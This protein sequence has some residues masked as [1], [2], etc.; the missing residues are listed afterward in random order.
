MATGKLL[1]IGTPIGNLGDMSRRAVEAIRSCSRL[2]CE[3]TRH[4]RKLLSHFRISAKVESFHEHNEDQKA[5]EVIEAIAGGETIGL[6]S[7]A[8]MPVLSDPGFALVQAARERGITVEPIP[9]PVAAILALVASGIAP[10]PFTFYGFAPHRS[11]ERREFYRSIAAST[12]TAIVY[13]SPERVVDSLR[14]ALQELGDVAAT[15]AREMTKVHEEFLHGT[16]SQII[17]TLEARK[18]IKGEL[19]IVLAA[20]SPLQAH[21]DPEA[22][23]TEF[24]R[25]RDHG[26]RR[27]DALKLLAERYRIRKNELYRMLLDESE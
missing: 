16:L 13:E 19:T 3:D 22:I 12:T 10:Q 9:G 4:T 21:V 5:A 15:V 27:N 6:V 7:D 2:L 24:R 11:G 14:D 20:A 17:A 26:M 1:V 23:R 8:G 18:K 25:L